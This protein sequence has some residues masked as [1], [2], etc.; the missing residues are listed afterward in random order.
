[1]ESRSHS[2]GVQSPGCQHQSAMISGGR[3]GTRAAKRSPT[4]VPN[5]R[6]REELERAERAAS[7]RSSRGDEELTRVPSDD[8]V[9]HGM[10]APMPHEAMGVDSGEIE[11]ISEEHIDEPF[12]PHDDTVETPMPRHARAQQHPSGFED[13]ETR[14]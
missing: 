6:L 7:R 8:R 12:V 1:M 14:I 3:G 2:G 13:E 11:I 10:T 4:M 9:P 5:R